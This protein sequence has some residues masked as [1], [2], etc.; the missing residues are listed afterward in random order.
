M[1][2]FA[3]H[4]LPSLKF[5]VYFIVAFGLVFPGIIYLLCQI[6]FPFQANG[7]LIR[8]SKGQIIG[9]LLIAQGFSKPYYFHPRPSAAGNGYDAAN[10]GGTNLGPTSKKLFLGVHDPKNPSNNFDGVQDLAVA[11]RKENGLSPLAK[12]PV[13]AVTRSASGLDPDISIENAELQVNRIAKTRHCTAHQINSI[14]NLNIQRPF[15]GI[16]GAECV[17]V[18][19]LNLDLNRYLPLNTQAHNS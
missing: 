17:N 2:S 12:V 4:L 3:N 14:I 8:N 19:K 1:K 11:Y 6:L 15:L 9:S 16:F 10:S 7:S 5:N 18:L 13:D